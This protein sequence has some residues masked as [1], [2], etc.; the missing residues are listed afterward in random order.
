MDVVSQRVLG[1]LAL[2]G[3]VVFV[4]TSVLRVFRPEVDWLL[5][6]L[7]TL[8]GILLVAAGVLLWRSALRRSR[9][10]EQAPHDR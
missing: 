2:V 9:R 7:N 6:V 5:V 10:D 1:T 4:S 8:Y 3:G